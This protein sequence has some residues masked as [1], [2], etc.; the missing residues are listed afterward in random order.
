[1]YD[2]VRCVKGR[3]MGCTELN[4]GWWHP[5]LNELIKL[6]PLFLSTEE[7][8]M[9]VKAMQSHYRP[10]QAMKVPAG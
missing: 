6:L 4:S 5:V 10:G 7:N 2:T 8:Y 3:A 9:K 1:M